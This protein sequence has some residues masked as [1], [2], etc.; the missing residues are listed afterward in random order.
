MK[1]LDT[2]ILLRYLLGDDPEQGEV[3]RK[4]IEDGGFTISEVIMEIIYVLNKHYKVPK[5]E[6]A[7][8]LFSLSHGVDFD[9]KE[10]ILY[11]LNVYAEYN[12]D[13]VDCLLIARGVSLKEEIITFDK[14]IKKVLNSL[15][16]KNG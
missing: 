9:N 10:I 2:N 4:V 12:L 6:I 11:A 13:Y 5:N 8:S 3:A 14:K 1:T 7:Q 16:E 15:I